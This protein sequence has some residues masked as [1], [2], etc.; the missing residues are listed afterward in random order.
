MHD[1]ARR[2][3]ADNEVRANGKAPLGVPTRRLDSQE[4]S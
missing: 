4:E 1:T 2:V 3:A